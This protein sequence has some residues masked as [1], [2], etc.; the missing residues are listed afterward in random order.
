[1]KRESAQVPALNALLDRTLDLGTVELAESAMRAAGVREANWSS[2]SADALRSLK[3]HGSSP[4]HVLDLLALLHESSD[5]KMQQMDLEDVT[6]EQV[7]AARSAL[8]EAI[9]DVELAMKKGGEKWWN[10]NCAQLAPW[11]WSFRVLWPSLGS[12]D[13]LSKLQAVEARASIL[14]TRLEHVAS[15]QL[16]FCFDP[17]MIKIWI[18]RVIF[19]SLFFIDGIRQQPPRQA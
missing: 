19:D 14:M 17:Q 16:A 12:K 11:L 3:P 7:A 9:R 6:V 15:T 10:W 5:K 4:V 18:H 2:T 8:R 1:M 13:Q